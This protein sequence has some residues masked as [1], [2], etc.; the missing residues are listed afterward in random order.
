MTDFLSL[1]LE[2]FFTVLAWMIFVRAILSWFPGAQRNQLG[3]FL[4]QVTDP[5]LAPLRR[6]IPP[7]GGVIDLT[8]TIAFIILMVAAWWAGTLR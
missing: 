5:I 7:I 4:M 8:P 2:I 6:I 1:F 3:A